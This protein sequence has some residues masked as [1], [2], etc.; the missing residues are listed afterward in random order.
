MPK[1]LSR[2]SW[3]PNHHNLSQHRPSWS[4]SRGFPHLPLPLREG[5]MFY[6]TSSSLC[7]RNPSLWWPWLAFGP[8]S[9][10]SCA[11]PNIKYTVSMALPRERLLRH[12]SSMLSCLP[13]SSCHRRN[14]LSALVC[15]S[16][17]PSPSL[18]PLPSLSLPLFTLRQY[19]HV[20][21]AMTGRSHV[22]S[23]TYGSS[24]Y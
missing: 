13:S 16:P 2:S 21:S 12:S 24:G 20:P 3:R 8:H 19:S 15:R 6:R 17:P 4:S 7:W 10:D 11:V 9:I 23:V 5:V 22:C 1:R 14:T 18:S